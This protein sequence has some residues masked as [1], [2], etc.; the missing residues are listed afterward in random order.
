VKRAELELQAS[1]LDIDVARARFYPTFNIAAG[2]GLQAFNTKYL[3]TTPESMLYGI[4]GE[5]MVP[6]INRNA[7]TSAYYT[8]NSRQIQ[9]AYEYEQTILNAHIEVVNDLAKIE[10]MQRS[11]ELKTQ[12]VEALTASVD[13]SQSL[14]TSARAD[15]M[16][17]LMTQRDALEAKMELIETKAEQLHTYVN[18][19]QALGGGWR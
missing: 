14:F 7:I 17:V 11:L 5:L 13:I 15:Y 3:V 6:L 16:E 2:V 19:Y 10:N 4:A 8:A 18:V 1:D 12:Q 9:A